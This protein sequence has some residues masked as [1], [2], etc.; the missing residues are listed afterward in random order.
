MKKFM[1]VVALMY[2]FVISNYAQEL[3]ATVEVNYEQLDSNGKDKLDNFKNQIEDYLN[4][5]KFTGQPWEGGRIQCSFNVLFTSY[6]NETNFS[7]QVVVTSQRPIEGTT[8]NSLMLM[9]LD[10]KWS[11][12]YEKNQSMY[13]N[14][15]DFD[16]LISFLNYYAYIIIG[17]D[18]D[19]YYRLGGSDFFSKALEIAVRG[20]SSKYS[21]GWQSASTSYNRR[22]LVD[23]LLN[24][25]YQ[26]L[27]MDSFDYHYN[28]IDL[29]YNSQT[30]Q[31]AMKNIAKLITDLYK[32]KDQ[33]DARSVYLKVFF[34]AKAGEIAGYLKSFPN[35]Q[36][37][38]NMMVK[39]D[40]AHTSKY[41]DALSKE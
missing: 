37:L 3:E 16:P 19:S 33:L 28:G 8:G 34:D 36:E 35:K 41:E 27:R 9:I 13:F 23:N 40:P 32:V 21:D 30:K 24:A 38:V 20:A 39:I 12:K 11:F 1:F 4:N 29:F 2:G 5:T 15:T 22:V 18:M 7:A 26:Q 6:A 10:N 14:Q 31:Q 25:K 17:F